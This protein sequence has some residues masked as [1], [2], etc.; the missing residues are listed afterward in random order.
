MCNNTITAHSAAQI[1]AEK[2]ILIE[3]LSRVPGWHWIKSPCPRMIG[4]EEG[5]S[6]TSDRLCLQL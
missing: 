1:T 3:A 2:P 6:A 5:V 4:H